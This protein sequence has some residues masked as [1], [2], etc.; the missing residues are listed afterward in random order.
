MST[1]TDINIIIMLVVITHN[2]GQKMCSFTDVLNRSGLVSDSLM[3]DGCY[4]IF[5]HL[6]GYAMAVAKQLWTEKVR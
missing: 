2:P 5:M 6:S 4:A 1:Q 3:R